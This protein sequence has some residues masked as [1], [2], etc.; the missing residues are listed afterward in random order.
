MA[1]KTLNIVTI[2]GGSGSFAVLS[3]LRKRKESGANINISAIVAMSDSGGSTGVLMDQYGVLPAGDVRQSLVALSPGS[4]FL[5][6]LFLHRYTEGFLEGH[7]FGNIFLSTIEK[8]S[9]SFP[10]AIREAEQVLH[11]LG[12]TY[13]VTLDKHEL[14]VEM[15]NGTEIVSEKNLDHADLRNMGEIFFSNDV[16]LNPK[17]IK[18]LARADIILINPGSFFTSI[19]PNFLVKELVIELKKAKAKKIFISNMLTEKEQTDDF[20]IINFLEKLEEFIGFS[21][22]DYVLYNTN[23]R[24]GYEIVGR[25]KVEGKF[26]VQID[27]I[28]EYKKTK[29]IGEDFLKKPNKDSINKNFIRYDAKK[30]VDVILKL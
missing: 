20:S 15:K 27:D 11:T 14:V 19:I 22:F 2:G 23:H 30:L 24:V 13:P 5:R 12:K 18:V 25:Y 6:K 17:L 10:K 7:N 26:F 9:D 8:I 1:E 21:D 28:L 4:T 3:E 16:S 29:F